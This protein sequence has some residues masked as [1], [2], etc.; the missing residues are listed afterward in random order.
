VPDPAAAPPAEVAEPGPPAAGAGPAEVA[1][2][3]PAASAEGAPPG[4]REPFPQDALRARPSGGR[5]GPLAAVVGVLLLAGVLAGS[6]WLAGAFGSRRDPGAPASTTGAAVTRP[7]GAT[8]QAP[9]TQAPTTQAPTT[10]APTTQA[11]AAGQ[12][13]AGWTSFSRDGA[14]YAVGIPAGWRERTRDQFNA[15]VVEEERG[16]RRFT[17]RSTNPA[18]PLPAASQEYRDRY[19]RNLPGYRQLRFDEDGRYQ[20]RPAV[21]FE[22]EAVEDGQR[23][24]VSHINLK[25]RTWGYN[26]ELVTPAG[27]WEGSQELARQF[28]QAFRPLG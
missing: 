20:G 14:G 17:V 12:L 28:E 5:R 9:T 7:G 15:T 23:V 6:V 13:P 2:P 24:H 19:A 8:T 26:V 21:V 1:D 10:Q 16:D 25:G 3:A 4:R 27:Q 11:P 18:N 22:Y